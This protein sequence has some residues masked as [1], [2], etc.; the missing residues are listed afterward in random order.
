MSET[1][2]DPKKARRLA[3][4]RAWRQ[5][6]AARLNAQRRERA[7]V[8]RGGAPIGHGGPQK[9]DYGSRGLQHDDTLLA[10]VHERF[11]SKVNKDGPTQPHMD[12]NCWEWTYALRN[13]Y[14]VLHVKR[15]VLPAHHVS[16]VL[17]GLDIPHGAVVMHLCDHRAC[18]RVDHLRVATQ[19][20][21]LRDAVQKGRL[22]LGLNRNGQPG[23]ANPSA[24]LC[25]QDVAQIRVLSATGVKA[26]ALALQFGVSRHAIRLVVNRKTWTHLMEDL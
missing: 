10:Q 16:V 19:A 13:G 21:N 8:R 23:S 3:S 5:R 11:W 6:H 15:R 14:G 7:M 26:S 20:D 4:Q 12:T 17:H 1:M 2:I 18:V 25:E 9:G 22:I 24:K